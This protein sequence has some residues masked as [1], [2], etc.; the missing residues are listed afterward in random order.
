MFDQG[1][2]WL[3][4]SLRLVGLIAIMGFVLKAECKFPVSQE[5]KESGCNF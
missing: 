5:S 1:L 3:V 4:Y 2:K